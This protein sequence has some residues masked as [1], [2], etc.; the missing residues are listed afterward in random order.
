MS[1]RCAHRFVQIEVRLYK[2]DAIQWTSLDAKNKPNAP[3]SKSTTRDPHFKQTRL[4]IPL[5]VSMNRA[6]TDKSV[7]PTYP[8][9]SK[10]PKDWN[11]LEV[12]IKKEEKEE[13]PEGDAALNQ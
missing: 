4:S 9:S 7:P 11:K 3:P 2:V 1:V 5:L 10:N 13:K 6:A 8:S 12:E